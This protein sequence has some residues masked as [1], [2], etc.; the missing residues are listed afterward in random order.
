MKKL[1]SV[2]LMLVAS[3]FSFAQ[4]STAETLTIP[5]SV[6]P[7]IPEPENRI[8][9]S[10]VIRSPLN[11]FPHGVDG[12]EEAR[13]KRL[14]EVAQSDMKISGYK[15]YAS[16]GTGDWLIRLETGDITVVST[17][18]K[19]WNDLGWDDAVLTY[20]CPAKLTVQDKSGKY[21]LE[22][23]ISGPDEVQ[24]MPKKWMFDEADA[25]K[26]MLAKNNADRAKKFTD[27][28]LK[29]KS[30]V[31]FEMIIKKTRSLLAD[32]FETQ[33]RKA[34]VSVFAVKGKPYEELNT[35]REKIFATNAKFGA[36]SKKNRIPKE[37]VDKV[38]I[39]SIPVWEKYIAD[40]PELE[41]QTKKGLIL[42][43]A[44]ANTWTGNYEKADS[45]LAQVSEAKTTDLVEEDSDKLGG[46]GPNII[47]TF[48]QAA[49]NLRNA[50]EFMK[51]YKSRT[52]INAW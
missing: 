50:T 24:S 39:E 11:P 2:L 37:E 29:Y 10:S 42:N 7:T 33:N 36:F 31:A 12:D 46:E 22:K 13:K 18:D 30:N 28:M 5:Y 43:C 25:G 48:Q 9:F 17:T 6:S 3:K 8:G 19:P 35:T 32:A 52:T 15:Y 1:L 34:H 49:E 44:L 16:P 20:K 27:Q 14:D 38:M 45:Y 21:I 47:L 4:K 23:E 41:E 40:H 51:Q 26:W